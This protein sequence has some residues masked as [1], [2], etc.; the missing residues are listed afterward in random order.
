MWKSPCDFFEFKLLTS[1]IASYIHLAFADS[2]VASAPLFLDKIFCP[3][4]C[5]PFKSDLLHFLAEFLKR[6]ELWQS[7]G[8]PVRVSDD[9]ST[10]DTR[11]QK[12]RHPLFLN[13]ITKKQT[14]AWCSTL[15]LKI[16]IYWCSGTDGFLFCCWSI[17][18]FCYLSMKIEADMMLT[19]EL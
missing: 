1:A 12:V 5:L 4:L 8:I 2:V 6:E 10:Y 13:A 18:L 15:A 11:Y 14:P 9:D 16:P 3:C 19:L 17:D 7:L